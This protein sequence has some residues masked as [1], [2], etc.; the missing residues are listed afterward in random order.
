MDGYSKEEMKRLNIKN[1]GSMFLIEFT[2]AGIVLFVSLTCAFTPVCESANQQCHNSSW[3][4]IDVGGGSIKR[5]LF[6]VDMDGYPDSLT[7]ARWY[8]NPG[9]E[10]KPWLSY[11]T[12]WIKACDAQR[13]GDINSDGLPDIALGLGRSHP[14]P[15]RNKVYILLNPDNLGKWNSY[16]IGTLPDAPDGVETVAICDINN[17]GYPDILAG[18]ECKQLRCYLNPGQNKNNWDSYLICSFSPRDV[19]GM[20]IG[21]FNIDGYPDIVVTTCSPHGIRGGT[22]LLIN[23]TIDTEEWKRIILDS[24]LFSCIESIATGD[25][26]DDGWSDVV[27]A[28]SQPFKESYLHWYENPKGSG[29]WTRHLVDILSSRHLK[30]N[31]PALADIDMD[32]KLDIICHHFDDDIVY[33]Y[34]QNQTNTSWI[35]H[36]IGS[37]KSKNNYAIGDVDNDGDPDLVC[38]GKAYINPN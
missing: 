9:A 34:E 33:W 25:I 28:N 19:E 18:G 11:S 32:E 23:P 17:D 15:D 35:K 12:G 26:N 36:R 2:C 38:F 7:A 21:D 5:Y 10:N 3:E 16:H 4:I 6:D 24:E 29:E 1:L 14:S 13:V 31:L 37:M 20:A 22:Y 8:K 27:L 30:G